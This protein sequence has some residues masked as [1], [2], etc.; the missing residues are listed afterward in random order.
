MPFFAIKP[1]PSAWR[2]AV[3]FMTL[4]LRHRR[5][6]LVFD[7]AYRE[8]LHGLPLDPIRGEKILASLTM[9]HIV[10]GAQVSRPISAAMKNLLLAHEATYLESLQDPATLTRILGVPISPGDHEKVLS[11]QRLMVGGTIQATRLAMQGEPVVVHLG[12]GF[13]HAGRSRGAGFCVFNDVA[14][15]ILRLRQRGFTGNVLVV[16]LDLHDGNGT[17]EIF[18]QDSTVFTLSI[19]N[20]HWDNPEAVASLSLALGSGVEDAQYL[21]TVR[22]ALKEVLERFQPELVFYLAGS[23]VAGDDALGDWLISPQGVLARDQLVVTTFRQRKVPVIVLLGGGYGENAWRYPARFLAWLLSGETY[24]PPADEVV[25]LA[26]LRQLP[27][28]MTEEANDET[29]GLTEEDLAGILPGI[30]VERK[31]LGTFSQV[32]VELMLE[33]MG[34]LQQIRAKG[35]VCPTVA[36]ELDHPLGHTLRIFGDPQRQELLMELRLARTSGAVPGFEL[37]AVEWLLLQNPRASFTPQRP[38]LPGQAHPGLGLLAEVFAWLV[39]LCEKLG[40]DGLYF[41]PSHFHLAALAR[42]HAA[43]LNPQ[44]AA[45]FDALFEMLKDQPLAEASRLVHEGKVVDARTGQPVRWG[46]FPM[47]LPVSLRLREQIESGAYQKAQAQARQELALAISHS[48]SR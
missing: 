20:Q 30:S 8:Q 37:L 25:A 42:K 17:R 3:R 36:L 14:V 24:E 15:A 23:D 38:P 29:W 26:R 48:E 31:F 21:A 43:F 5:P 12:G 40:L 18:A 35:F 16:D 41:R 22:E 39:L 13:H 34:F 19:H 32:G 27:G 33:R 45:L 6:F 11:L 47:V 4:K 7:G 1:G 44:D 10:G 28:F 2:R 9:E 46:A